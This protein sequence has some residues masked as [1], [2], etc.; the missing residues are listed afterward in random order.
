M[1]RIVV[2]AD[3]SPGSI[4]ALRWAGSLAGDQGAE[5]VAMTGFVPKESKVDRPSYDEL[6]AQRVSDLD[7]WCR[8]ADLDATAVRHIVEQG[9][10][11]PAILKV[12]E[13]EHADLVVVGR[14]GA[15]AGPGL[16]H[17]GSMAEWLAHRADTTIA[18]IGGAVNTAVRRVIVGVDGSDGSRAALAWAADLAQHGDIEIVVAAVTD[19]SVTWAAS[20]DVDERSLLVEDRIRKDWAL[21]LVD[22]GV[23][24]SVR[25]SWGGNYA[26]SL[27]ESARHERA[28]VVV[29]GMR[30]IGGFPEL[31]IGGVALKVLHR[32]D[33]PV[34]LVPPDRR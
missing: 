26:D 14:E 7:G 31:R 22:R 34:V 10:P 21:P 24:F 2:G 28:D 27:L 13:R 23:P 11:R 1:K 19:D 5:V 16:L 4:N 32:A 3:G 12:A 17:I 15:S 25:T 30:G 9:D 29:V 33:R 20:Y 18:V 8:A 6:L